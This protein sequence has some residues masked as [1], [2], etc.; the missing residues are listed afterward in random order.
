MFGG[1]YLGESIWSRTAN[2]PS[3]SWQLVDPRMVAGASI[4]QSPRSESPEKPILQHPVAKLSLSRLGIIRRR[5]RPPPQHAP[6]SAESDTQLKP[7]TQ[8]EFLLG[9]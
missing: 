6:N 9:K 3:A 2:T 8:E 1:D 7:R 4:F 5:N